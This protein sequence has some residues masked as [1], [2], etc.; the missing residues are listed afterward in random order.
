[1]VEPSAA[2]RRLRPRVVRA[3]LEKMRLRQTPRA[4]SVRPW[5]L[6]IDVDRAFV[7]EHRIQRCR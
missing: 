1:M 6:N 7:A 2:V 4:P 3:M 5:C